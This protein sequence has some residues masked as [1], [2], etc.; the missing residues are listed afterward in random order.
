M[1]RVQVEGS[2]MNR[3]CASCNKMFR[4]DQLRRCSGCKVD[5]Y[6]SKEC[7]EK[8]WPQHRPLCQAKQLADKIAPSVMKNERDKEVY[9]N[10][11]LISRKVMECFSRINGVVQEDMM[12]LMKNNPGMVLDLHFNGSLDDAKTITPERVEN[13]VAIGVIG[14]DRKNLAK[15]SAEYRSMVKE[16]DELLKTPQAPPMTNNLSLRLITLEEAKKS[17]I[18]IKSTA[19]KDANDSWD[20]GQFRV[21]IST[22]MYDHGAYMHYIRIRLSAKN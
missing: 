17:M 19:S 12:Q 18:G 5:N 10:S 14:L 20:N 8:H 22:D 16:L 21:M 3:N 15:R 11:P 6:C 7:Q 1:D 9:E 13:T 4:M 2:N